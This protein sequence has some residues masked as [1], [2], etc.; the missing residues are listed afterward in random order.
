VGVHVCVHTYRDEMQDIAISFCVCAMVQG[1][2]GMEPWASYM[3]R[4]RL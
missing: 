2:K 1:M 4:Q 3:V